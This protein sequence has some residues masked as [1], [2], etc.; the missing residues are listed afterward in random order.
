MSGSG[1]VGGPT[2]RTTGRV[3]M[4]AAGEALWGESGRYVY[5]SYARLRAAHFPMLPEELPIVIGL[6][7]Y[8]HCLG[9]TRYPWE[10]GARITLAPLIF[11]RGRGMVD[12]VLVHEMLHAALA[13]DGRSPQHEGEDW[14]AEVRRLSPAVLGH[15][16]QG[17]P[18]R[19]KSVRI[20]NP[21]YGPDDRQ[22]GDVAVRVGPRHLDLADEGAAGDGPSPA[23]VARPVGRGFGPTTLC[24]SRVRPRP[25]VGPR[26]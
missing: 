21:N 8:G 2:E 15:G 7:A 17:E 3:A 13:V 6:T 24:P 22:A 1:F 10:H 9:L 11:R 20:P 5:A 12:D 23:A 19:R 26:W 4:A 14:Y 16:L 18:D 25:S